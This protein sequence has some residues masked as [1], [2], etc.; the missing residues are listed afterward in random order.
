MSQTRRTQ[1][2]R[3]AQR[4]F[5][6]AGL[7]VS[8][9]RSDTGPDGIPADIEPRFAETIRA[10]REYTMTSPE[11]I[12]AACTSADYVARHAIPGAIVEC[13]VWRGGSTMAIARTLSETD[14]D[15]R[16]FYLF[17]TYAGMTEPT[18][19]DRSISGA[20]A[21]DRWP[22]MQRD[23]HNEWDFA[24][25]A[26][27]RANMATTGY[28]SEL[29]HYVVGDVMNTLPS[30]AP[31]QIAL[32]RLDTDWYESTRHELR[33]LFPR[34]SRGGVLIVDDYGHWAGARRAVDEFLA[35]S[36]EPLLFARVD[37]TGRIAVRQ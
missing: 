23:T 8:R 19:H 5:Y 35:E 21:T 16:E 14:N 25:L 37:Y 18:E 11:R 34:L 30:E 24:P 22:A 3:A 12:Y 9:R 2:Q 15:S 7:Q 6:R 26:D 1:L 13:G 33:H 4:A 20:S 36:G 17:D 10:V 29:I 31:E 28:P 32:L 27:V